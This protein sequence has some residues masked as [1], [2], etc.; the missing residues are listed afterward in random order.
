MTR[1]IQSGTSP[2]GN[3]NVADFPSFAISFATA[4]AALIIFVV[5]ISTLILILLIFN[6]FHGLFI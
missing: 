4:P 3:F 1:S 2:E 6:F 5:D